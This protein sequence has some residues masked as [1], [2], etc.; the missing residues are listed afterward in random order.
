MG[1]L[2]LPKYPSA[3]DCEQH[4][5]DWASYIWKAGEHKWVVVWRGKQWPPCKSRKNARIVMAACKRS[6]EDTPDA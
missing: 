4:S 3:P 6:A 5:P 2:T 1:D